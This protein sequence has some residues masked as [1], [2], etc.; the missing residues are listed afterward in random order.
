MRLKYPNQT[1]ES[2]LMKI[3][4]NK[5]L[6]MLPIVKSKHLSSLMMNK[7]ELELEQSKAML[8]NKVLEQSK[9]LNKVNTKKE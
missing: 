4:L 9:V 2:I 3:T 8:L 5:R 6:S 7:S 1:V